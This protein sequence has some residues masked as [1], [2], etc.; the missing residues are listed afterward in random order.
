MRQAGVT[1]RRAYEG[2][3]VATSVRGE[4]HARSIVP[5]LGVY[6]QLF[7]FISSISQSYFAKI[8]HP[9]RK[10]HQNKKK[11]TILCPNSGPFSQVMCFAVSFLGHRLHFALRLS[12]HRTLS[13]INYPATLVRQFFF[14]HS[15]CQSRLT[16][17]S[18]PP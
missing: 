1:L 6:F 8:I 3:L 2:C 17:L 14:F 12:H 9:F 5:L 16:I 18:L 10:K 7:P 11:A 13:L 15:V 4:Q